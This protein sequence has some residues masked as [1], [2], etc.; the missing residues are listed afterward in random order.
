[1]TSRHWT[2]VVLL[3]ILLALALVGC[4]R[5]AVEKPDA[6][7]SLQASQV[8]DGA[9]PDAAAAESRSEPRSANDFSDEFRYAED[10]EVRPARP[11]VLKKKT[12]YHAY[13]NSRFGFRVD[14]PASF[15]DMPE[16]ENGDGM[17]WRLGKIAV[18]AAS[19]INAMDNETLSCANSSNVTAHTE[20]KTSC[21][22]TGR[23][24]GYIYWEREVLRRG[25]SFSLRMQYLESV[26]ELMDPI[27]KRV[28]ASWQIFGAD[29]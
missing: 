11:E 5:Q 29:E 24:D 16:P 28:N 9:K 14:I 13:I 19:G 1:M 6:G 25:V 22:S 3:P 10:T 26:K 12:A 20:S 21:W 15:Q 18:I 7:A 4:R 8:D 17:Q 27:V 23:K 2:I